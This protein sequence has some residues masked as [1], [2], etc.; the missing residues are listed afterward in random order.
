MQTFCKYAERCEAEATAHNIRVRV[1]ST[2]PERLPADVAAAI[3]KMERNTADGN[4]RRCGGGEVGE[5]GEGVINGGGAGGE[6]GGTSSSSSSSSSSS[7]GEAEAASFE[8]NLCVSYGSRGDIAAAAQRIARRVEAGSLRAE[9]VTEDT[10]SAR[11]T[12][13][14]MDGWMDGRMD[15]WGGS[16]LGA[17]RACYSSHRLTPPTHKP[18]R[19]IAVSWSYE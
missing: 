17:W 18:P 8:L 7:E 6:G 4:R 5:A 1:L 14:W 19:T 15:G 3:A 9:D 11:W 16:A 13:R 2:E 12:E 10:V